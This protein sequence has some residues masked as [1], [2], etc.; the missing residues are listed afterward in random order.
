MLRA[1]G[2]LILNYHL[3]FGKELIGKKASESSSIMFGVLLHLCV[4]TLLGLT[5]YLL[6]LPY[7]VL[8]GVAFSLLPWLVMM[9][10]LFPMFGQGIFGKRLDKR[11]PWLTLVFHI[12]YGAI[13]GYF[14]TL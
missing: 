1:R 14:A 5:Y 8:T 4:G 9:L 12:I 2:K 11:T 6:P 10:I 7:G 3:F 13:L